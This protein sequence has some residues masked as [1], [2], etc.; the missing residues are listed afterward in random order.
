MQNKNFNITFLVEQTPNEV[1]NAINNVRGWWSEELEG[2][3]EK[4]NDEFSY[5]H[6]EFHYS[7]HKLIEVDHDKKVVWLTIDSKLTFVKEQ[8]EWNGTKM[9]FEI[10]KQGGKTKLMITHLGLV[11]EFECFDACSKG[12]TH[13]L[14]NSLLPLIIT[15]TGK[16]DPKQKI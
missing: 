11:P 15:G 10:L 14:Q 7:K 9:I 8:D 4:L 1:F 12:W 3:S 13:Y 5:R 6:G 2:N 16:P